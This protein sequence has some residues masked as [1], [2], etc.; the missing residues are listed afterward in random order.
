[1][2][3]LAIVI[4]VT[5]PSQ[6]NAGAIITHYLILWIACSFFRTVEF[7]GTIAAIVIVIACPLLQNTFSIATREFI[8]STRLI[9]KWIQILRIME[10]WFHFSWIAWREKRKRNKFRVNMQ[11]TL[12][13]NCQANENYKIKIERYK[14]QH[15]ARNLKATSRM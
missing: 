10:R 9:Y 11:N 6:R 7:V 15:I 2:I 14:L 12:S 13:A 4:T 3:I 1:M 5:T 8:R